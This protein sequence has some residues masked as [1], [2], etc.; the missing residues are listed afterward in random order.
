MDKYTNTYE[1]RQSVHDMAD[2]GMQNHLEKSQLSENVH[3][4]KV[5]PDAKTN[6]VPLFWFVSQIILCPDYV[7]AINDKLYLIEVKG[8]KKLKLT[9]YEKLREMYTKAIDLQNQI[10]KIEIALMYFSH[11]NAKPIWINFE[12]LQE[13][14]NSIDKFEEYP[15]KDF[16]GKP[17]LYKVLPFV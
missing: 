15:E 6:N 9:D 2:L 5:G 4:A 12:K 17:K 3:W 11:P 8:T 7:V 1:E 14:W 13:M 16:A 10:V